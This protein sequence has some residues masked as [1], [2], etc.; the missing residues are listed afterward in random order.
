MGKTQTVDA[1]VEGGKASAAPPLG[2]SLGPLKVNIGQVVAEINAKTKDFKGMKVPVKVI[3]DIETKEFTIEI[4][5]PPA[6]QLIMKEINIDKGSGEQLKLKAGVISIEQAFKVARMKESS[7][8]VNNIRSAVKTIV[9]SCQ[10]AGILVDGKE[11]QE[12][13]KELDEGKHD[14]IFESGKTEPDADKKKKL[15]ALAGEL[16]EK[17]QLAKKEKEAAKAAAEAEA[18]AKATAAPTEGAKPEEKTVVPKPDKK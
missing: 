2:S 8:I 14:A 10:S 5:T 15:G 1:L 9:G 17:R 16:S 6:T 7:L 11:P 13:L 3:V 4:G 18:A 12:V